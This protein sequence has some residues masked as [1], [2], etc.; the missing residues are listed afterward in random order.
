MEKRTITIYTPDNIKKQVEVM[1]HNNAFILPNGS[2]VLAKG[3]TGCNPSHQLESSALQIS[4]QLISPDIRAQYEDF[5]KD[6][7]LALNENNLPRL[8]YLR[9]ILVEYYGWALF[10]RTE[11]FKAWDDSGH[12]FEESLVPNSKYYGQIPTSEQI[13]T[14]REFFD[15]N[16]DGTVISEKNGNPSKEASLMRILSYENNDS[17]H[18]L[19]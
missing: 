13:H 5:V 3:Y 7:E 19:F 11:D 16:D 1:K 2:Y 14:L 8:Y 15:I 18:R 10:A 6:L 9:A 17:W 4:R 12:F